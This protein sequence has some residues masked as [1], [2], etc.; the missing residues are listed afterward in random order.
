[1][2]IDGIPAPGPS[3]LTKRKIG[4]GD[5]SMSAAPKFCQAL[6]PGQRTR[7]IG[8]LVPLALLARQATADCMVI[9]CHVIEDYRIIGLS[10]LTINGYYWLLLV[11]N[12]YQWLLIVINGY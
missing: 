7:R 8:A 12:G 9:Q 4:L 5:T 6:V 3:I 11:I 2:M 10:K 1:M